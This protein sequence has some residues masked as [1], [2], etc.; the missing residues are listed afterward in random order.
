MDKVGHNH[1]GFAL[2]LVLM[3]IATGAVVGMSYLYGASVKTASAANL[4]LA[5]RARYLAESGLAH[6]LFA[7][8]DNPA[9][10]GSS[11]S[12]VEPYFADNTSDTYVFYIASVG[13]PGLFT[14][15]ATGTVGNITQSVSMNVQV[16]NEY[17]QKVSD[18]APVSWWR[19]GDTGSTAVDQIGANDGVYE[20]GVTV[21]AGGV[22]VG[23]YDTAADFDGYNDYVDLNDM[24]VY[25]QGLTIAAWARLDDWDY[26]EGHIISKSEEDDRDK[27]YWAILTDGDHKLR[28]YLRAGTSSDAKEVKPDT[29]EVEAGQWFFVVGTYDGSKMR[30]YKDGVFLKSCDNSGDIKT[31]A[32]IETWIGGNA[33][34]TMNRRWDGTIDEVFILNYPLSDSQIQD[35]FETRSAPKVEVVLWNE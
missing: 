9:A 33:S 13:S 24:D 35:L 19:L 17:A 5:S 11:Q 3:L 21:G 34:G 31:N 16:S 14:V 2:L 6:G 1:K 4:V 20:N 30:L 15:T 26:N 22:I 7:L 28:F 27:H 25:G 10:Q 23:D 12:P 8:Q 18:L 32:G 29:G